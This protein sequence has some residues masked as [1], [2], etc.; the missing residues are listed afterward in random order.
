MTYDARSLDRS[1]CPDLALMDRALELAARGRGA[2]EPNPQVGCVIVRDGRIVGEG[3]HERYGGPHAEVHALRQAGESARGATLYVTLE[4]CSHFGKTPPC[5]QAVIA[6][7][8]ARAVIAQRDPFPAVDGGGI[9]ELRAAGV[10]IELGVREAAAR[11]LN[12][13]YLKLVTERRP[14]IIAKWA[15]SLDG[16]IATRTG[17]SRWISCES[18]RREVHA[19]RGRVDAIMVGRGTAERDD[20]LLTARPPGPR[21]ATRVV[22]DRLA[23]LAPDSQLARTAREFPTLVAISPEAPAARRAALTACGCELLEVPGEASAEFLGALFDEMGRRRWTNVLV[24]GG[25]ALLG[26]MVDARLLDE[27]HVYLA[28]KL[29]GGVAAPGAVHG[30]GLDKVADASHWQTL[31]VDRFEDDVR[32]IVRRRSTAVAQP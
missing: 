2:V 8:V 6:A 9:A 32:L 21:V 23:R 4:P 31:A 20:P 5:S 3:W 15:M 7:G 16:K 14:W 12:A 11:E 18:S 22:V 26:S 17:D 1:T 30:L 10:E 25:A 29:I 24:E 19:L 27:L 13:A 28:P